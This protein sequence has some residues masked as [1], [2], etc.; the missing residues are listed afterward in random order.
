M[1]SG[2]RL[3]SYLREL[4][5]RA[6][7]TVD[8]EMSGAAS[9]WQLAGKGWQ[10][11]VVVDPAR[12][13]GLEFVAQDSLDRRVAYDI[14]TDLYDLSHEKHRWFADEIERDIVEFLDNLWRGLVLRRED[15]PKLMLVFPL[16]GAY[17]RVVQARFLTSASTYADLATAQDGGCYLPVD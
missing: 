1:T 16:G 4:P 5:M 7:W 15:G 6:A 9:R 3:L 11:T 10:A 2:T 8:A 14:D 17:V 13:I 12:W